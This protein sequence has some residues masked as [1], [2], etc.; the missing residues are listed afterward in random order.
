MPMVTSKFIIRST[1]GYF[2]SFFGGP[3]YI[4]MPSKKKTI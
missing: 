1:T 2:G 3:I 4:S